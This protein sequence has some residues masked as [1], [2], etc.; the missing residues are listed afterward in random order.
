MS[1]YLAIGL[2]GSLGAITRYLLSSW[3]RRSYPVSFPLA[4]WLVNISGSF[5][6]GAY[7]GL[8]PQLLLESHLESML[9]LGFL[10][11]YTTFSTFIYEGLTLLQ[12]QKNS[13]AW[14]YLLS[15]LAVGI[16]AAFAGLAISGL[17]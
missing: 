8:E 7:V 6:L 1:F 13:Q 12:K 17:I 11:S 9:V 4:T 5:L 14:F 3:I 2:G 10:S 16:L 15:S